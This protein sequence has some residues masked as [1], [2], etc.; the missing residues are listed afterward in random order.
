MSFN[1]FISVFRGPT[2]DG[3]AT[4]T[5][6]SIDLDPPVQIVATT[7]SLSS[8]L[9]P[10]DIAQAI[11]DAV[12]AQ[13]VLE[14]KLY[15]GQPAFLEEGAPFTFRPLITDH[16]VTLWSQARFKLKAT[17]SSG[18]LLADMTPAFVTRDQ[19]NSIARSLGRPLN[20]SDD[21]KAQAVLISSAELIAGMNGNLIVAACYI[22]AQPGFDTRGT[23][24]PQN[25]ILHCDPEI[26]R[27]PSLVGFTGVTKLIGGLPSDLNAEIGHVYY[28]D[29]PF[30]Y[31][32]YQRNT[33]VRRTYV[34][35]FN[36]IPVIVKR[37]ACELGS[38][39]MVP[40][41]IASVKG[42]SGQVVLRVD[43]KA[44]QSVLFNVREYIL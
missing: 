29:M 3:V 17:L 44:L 41:E 19:L 2:Q 22:E 23:V 26:S 40:R 24:F 33:Q 43:G 9:S 20:L 18:V 14:D 8:S 10:D 5:I 4:I 31:E 13:L 39:A 25:N 35:G 6:T 7:P 21:D 30:Q 42:G 32:P 11:F 37:S 1:E 27:S 15:S 16:V 12:K 36:S 34:A 28:P 38:M